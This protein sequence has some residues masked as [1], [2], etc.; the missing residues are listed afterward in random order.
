MTTQCT[1]T[2]FGFQALYQREV[3]ARFD[4]GDITTDAGGLLLRE[5]ERR[6]G[7]IRRLAACFSDH[8]RQDR[9]EHGVEELIA[10]RFTDW[11]WAMRISTTTTN[12]GR[13]R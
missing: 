7:V 1:Q 2:E 4:G 10:Q 13:I 5:V 8:R 11:L 9:V 6:T 3:V 12:C